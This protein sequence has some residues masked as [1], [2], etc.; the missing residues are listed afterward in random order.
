MPSQQGVLARRTLL[1]ATLAG[2]AT[3]ALAAWPERPIRLVIG[4]PP[5]GTGDLVGRLIGEALQQRLGVTVVADNQGGAGGAIAARGI[6]RAAPDGYTFMLAGNAIFAIQ[7]HITANVGYDPIDGFTAIANI[8]ESNRMLAVRN[9]L[10]APTL[11]A[12]VA[13][14][15]ANPGKLNYGS[16]GIGSPARARSSK[17][18]SASS[19]PM[20]RTARIIAGTG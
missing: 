15:K 19:A 16:S 3:P 7:P 12:F 5:G 18:A 17:A 1:G 10:P 6:T 2:L 8:S 11:V 4:Y 9:T 20:C 14:A 13:Y